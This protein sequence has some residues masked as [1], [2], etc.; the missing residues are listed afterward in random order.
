[1][2]D[3]TGLCAILAEQDSHRSVAVESKTGKILVLPGFSRIECGDRSGGALLCYGGL[4]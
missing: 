3:S 4:S 2:V 1:M